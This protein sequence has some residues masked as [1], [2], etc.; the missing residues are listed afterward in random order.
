MDH[1]AHRSDQL[2]KGRVSLP[3]QYY[4]I[5]FKTAKS[6]PFLNDSRVAETVIES[7]FYLHDEKVIDLV[8]FVGMPNHLHFLAALLEKKTLS[9]AMHSLKSFT[10]NEANRL[11][12]KIDTSAPEPVFDDDE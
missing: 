6:E 8:G 9:E 12:D 3:G 2:R 1:N 7:L 11:L 4:F 10:A 5:T